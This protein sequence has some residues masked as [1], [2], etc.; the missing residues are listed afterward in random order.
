MSIS[1]VIISTPDDVYNLI[2]SG[3]ELSTKF[4]YNHSKKTNGK[5]I[6]LQLGRIWINNLL[7]DDFPLINEPVDK[8]KLDG[9]IIDLYHK[10]GTEET[11]KIITN[12]QSEAFKLATLSPNTFNINIF[13]PPKEWIKK[14]EEFQKTAS[15]LSPLEFKKEAEVLTKELIKYIEDSGF[16]IENV[17]SSGAK[18]NPISDWGALLIAKGYVIDVEGK[19]LGPITNG[20]NDGYGKIEYYQAGSEAR[21]NFYMRSALTAHPGYLTTKMVKANAG[22]QID[23]KLKDCGTKKTFELLITKDLVNLVLQRNYVNQAGNIKQIENAEQVLDKKIKLRSPLYCKS[24]KGICPTCYGNLYKTLNTHN[25]GILAGGAINTVGINAMMK[26]RHK[27]SSIAT[28]EVDFIDMAKKAGVDVNSFK[29]VLIVEKNSITAKIP[30][31]II[32]DSSDYD[33]VS[34]IDC[35]DKYQI[36]GVLN[37]QYGD[38]A[39]NIGF[40]TLPYAI[41]VDCFKPADISIDGHIITMN[42]ESGELMIKQEYYDDTFNERTVDRLF[43][44]G[45]KYITNPETLVMTIQDKIS[46]IDLVHIESIVS[47]MF[48]DS[49]DLTMPARLTDYKQFEIIG[50]KK[51]PYMISWLSG[52]SFENINRAIKVGLLDGKEAVMDPIEK[53][54]MERYSELE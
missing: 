51:L 11:S 48:R 39:E 28:K 37:I 52:L 38:T 17:L 54:V 32:V 1:N 21:K 34:L 50:Q 47:N 33:D 8:K 3:K 25:V 15:K 31:S 35:G 2:K 13:T 10:Y 27:S 40:I 5:V 12:L 24:E 6:N 22:L 29:D 36:N 16:R 14:K 43:E 53:T 46:G 30:C 41:M 26:M 45:A 7:P 23:E 42:Y 9:L 49:E 18:G 19:L 44:G 20:L 4:P